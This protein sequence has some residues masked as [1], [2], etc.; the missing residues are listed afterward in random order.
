MVCADGR[1]WCL[2]KISRQ[3]NNYSMPRNYIKKKVSTYGQVDVENAV[4]QVLAGAMTIGKAAIAFAIPKSTLADHVKLGR[5][6]RTMAKNGRPPVFTTEQE[7][8]LESYILTASKSFYGITIDTLRSVAYQFAIANNLKHNFDVETQKAGRDWY[9]GFIQRHPAISLRTPEA[10]SLN[11]IMAFN[12]D[13][14]KIFFENLTALQSKY[15]FQP[16]SIYNIDETGISTVQKCSKI[17]AQKGL[18]QVPKATSGER[19]VLTTVVCCMSAG[20]TFIPPMFIFKRKRMNELLMKGASS[21]MVATVSDSG[22]TNEDI[23]VDWLRHF[24]KNAKP[25]PEEPI[26]LILDNHESHIS[27]QAFNIC[28]DNGIHLLSL[29][30]HVSHKMQPLDLTFFSSIKNGYN[31]ECDLYMNGYNKECDLYMVNNQGKKITQYEVAE[32]F[33]RVYNRR[34]SIDK[35]KNG[36]EAAGICPMNIHKFQGTFD[37]IKSMQRD[38]NTSEISG[39]AVP[40]PSPVPSTPTIS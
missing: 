25:T 16:K 18:K 26:L 4:E 23:F 17:L 29:P 37:L 12:E 15:N 11:R 3:S 27:L 7:N 10:T 40:E 32:I 19:G 35:A 33:T 36:F 30:P 13:E 21:D 20:G 24:V 5:E 31:R 2:E 39:V 6:N 38:A 14:V 22:W 8:E 9:Y 34:A 28:K 1:Q